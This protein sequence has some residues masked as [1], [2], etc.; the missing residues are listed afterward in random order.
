MPDTP[1]TGKLEHGDIITEINDRKVQSVQEL[2]NAIAAMPPGAEVK[3]KLFRDGKQQDAT[4]KLGEQPDNVL[5]MRAPQREKTPAAPKEAIT[6]ADSIGLKVQTLTPATAARANVD[7]KAG[8]VVMKVT[9]NSPAAKAGLNVGDIITQ[10]IAPG[11]IS[12]YRVV[13]RA[14]F[15]AGSSIF[16]KCVYLILGHS[17]S[18]GRGLSERPEQP[19]GPH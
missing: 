2:R 4:I 18:P 16:P 15:N 10:V 9:R 11:L 5:A 1:A 7:V 13:Q 6:S 3:M 14:R 17:W 8:A 19:V 12:N